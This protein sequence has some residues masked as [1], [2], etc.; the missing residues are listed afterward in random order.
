MNNTIFSYRPKVSSVLV[1]LVFVGAL[2]YGS[3]LTTFANQPLVLKGIHL[4]ATQATIFFGVMSAVFGITFLCI[5]LLS[6]VTLIFPRNIELQTDKLIFPIG[7]FSKKSKEVPYSSIKRIYIQELQDQR[8]LY[9]EHQ[10]GKLTIVPS[11][12]ES[13]LAFERL[14]AGIHQRLQGLTHHSSGTPSGAP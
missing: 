7:F 10:R 1:G 2:L 4:S 11:M 5:L 9:I 6:V 12:L 14:Q 13:S 8:F 3:V